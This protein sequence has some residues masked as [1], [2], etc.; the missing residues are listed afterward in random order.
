M[1]EQVAE[2]VFSFSFREKVTTAWMPEVEQRRE[3]LPRMRGILKNKC[4][5]EYEHPHPSPL[6]LGEGVF[7]QS[8][9]AVIA[10]RSSVEGRL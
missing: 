10:R 5:I 2:K 7:Q 1:G 8:V 9:N 4:L 6:P 3:Q